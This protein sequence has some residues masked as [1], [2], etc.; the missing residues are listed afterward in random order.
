MEKLF[1]EHFN[2][3]HPFSH[4]PANSF[5]TALLLLCYCLTV[6]PL[7]LCISPISSP[8]PLHFNTVAQTK[9]I[10]RLVNLME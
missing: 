3:M 8:F 1:G 2:E 4:K 7:P 10:Q 5:K 6:A 9:G